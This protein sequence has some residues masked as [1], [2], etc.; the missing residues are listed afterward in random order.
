MRVEKAH[1]ERAAPGRADEMR[2]VGSVF[3]QGAD[4]V[5]ISCWRIHGRIAEVS[6]LA[7]PDYVGGHDRES[8]PGQERR[9][10]IEVSAVATEAMNAKYGCHRAHRL[11]DPDHH[12]AQFIPE[13]D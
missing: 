9:E 10:I 1:H 7:A 4:A 6:A 12:C 13:L 8:L 3:R 2:R 5:E 11:P